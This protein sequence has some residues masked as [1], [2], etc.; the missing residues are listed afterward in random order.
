MANVFYRDFTPSADFSKTN[1]PNYKECLE[2]FIQFLGNFSFF[3]MM[4]L[5]GLEN[6]WEYSVLHKNDA[7]VLPGEVCNHIVF[8]CKGAV[9]HFTGGLESPYIIEFATDC[10]F[11]SGLRSFK[12]QIKATDG[13]VCTKTTYGLKLSYIKY[14]QLIKD[15][16]AFEKLFNLMSEKAMYTLV[17]R[18][19][20]FQSM[21]AKG[22]YELMLSQHP[23]VFER[24]AMQDISNYL[25]IKA[26]TLS[27]LKKGIE[28]Q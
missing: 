11:S 3:S 7:I 10:N 25:G 14:Q 21:D 9:K 27:R 24:F 23:D 16:P 2:Y 15:K 13:F 5:Q 18:L 22:R 6:Y 28:R 1:K 20:S 12:D 19:A 8:I 4:D 17:S 26:E